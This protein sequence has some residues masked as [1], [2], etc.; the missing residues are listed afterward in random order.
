M[1]LSLYKININLMRWYE[2]RGDDA[3]GILEN[4]TL[5]KFNIKHLQMD[6]TLNFGFPIIL[7]P[8]KVL[9]SN[10]KMKQTKKQMA[11]EEER[12]T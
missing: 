10:I 2:S 11:I 8:T 7:A 1:F 6:N 3:Y 4:I 12:K 5:I 9:H